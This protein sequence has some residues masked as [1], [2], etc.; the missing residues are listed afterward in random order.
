MIIRSLESGSADYVRAIKGASKLLLNLRVLKWQTKSYKM[1][2]AKQ[3]KTNY[4]ELLIAT[5]VWLATV[6]ERQSP[7]CSE[8]LLLIQQGQHR[9]TD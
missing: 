3:N 1:T 9:A 6:S 4:K 7:K 2:I 8:P 5:Y